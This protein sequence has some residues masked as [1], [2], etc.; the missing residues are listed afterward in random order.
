MPRNVALLLV[1]CLL[2][3]CAAESGPETTV[4]PETTTTSA[5]STST[6]G[7]TTTTLPPRTPLIID[8][9]MASEGVMSV[10]YLL[11]QD[12]FDIRAITVSGTGLVHCEEGVAQVLGLLALTGT[13]D[14]AVA[15]G[16]ERPVEGQN[17]FP[18]SWRVGADGLYGLELPTGRSPADMAAPELIVSVVQNAAVPVMVYAD[19][20]QTNLASALRIDP[21]IAENIERVYAMGG[22]FE[23]SGNTVRNPDAEW[24]IWIDPVAADEVFRQLP[25]TLVPLDATN[26]VPL[27][28]FHLAALEGA[29]VSPAGEAIATMLQGHEQMASGGL[30]FW[31]QLTAALLVDPTYGAIEEHSVEVILDEDRSIAGVTRFAPTGATMSVLADVDVARF[32]RDFLSVLAGADVGD[33][34]IDPD[35][36][37]SFD[38]TEWSFDIPDEAAPGPFTVELVNDGD[39]AIAV[40]F[41][42]LVEGATLEDAEAWE[43][44]EQ[45][46]FYELEE[47]FVAGPGERVYPVIELTEPRDYVLYGLDVRPSPTLFGVIIISG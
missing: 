6:T 30:L 24:N 22:A 23:T 10:L 7:P 34:V 27:T 45:P 3:A 42:W 36:R 31:D 13:S 16:P 28:V 1:V 35:L 26:Q 5:S 8:T 12:D 41:G 4:A 20:P 18:T 32:E 17:A 14:V 15:C 37:F 2:A 43:T 9:D 29:V 25:I 33:I 11:A 38:G 39:G 40:T 44:V 19:G 47:V 46:P 21:S